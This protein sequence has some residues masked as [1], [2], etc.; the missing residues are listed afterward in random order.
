MVSHAVQD[1]GIYNAA[2][3]NASGRCCGMFSCSIPVVLKFVLL[4]IVVIIALFLHSGINPATGMPSPAEDKMAH[5]LVLQ[6]AFCPTQAQIARMVLAKQ[7][8]ARAGYG[9][10][11][12]ELE[13]DVLEARA[14]AR[15]KPPL[16]TTLGDETVH[17]VGPKQIT[18]VLPN[19]FNATVPAIHKVK[20]C[21]VE[22][23]QHAAADVFPLVWFWC[24][25]CKYSTWQRRGWS[26]CGMWNKTL[27]QQKACP[28]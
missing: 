27:V 18:A 12:A 9:Y 24:C 7:Q 15:L 2:Q 23:C 11:V 17:C 4:V 6:T 22:S 8:L 21:Q 16:R 10:F 28:I 19:W 1:R 26:T 5:S 3:M 14:A 13:D 25:D 20:C